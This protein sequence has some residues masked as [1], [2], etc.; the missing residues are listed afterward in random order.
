MRIVPDSTITLYTGVDID[1]DEQLVFKN[2]TN[3][4]AYFHS[5]IHPQ[6]VYTPCTVVRKTGRLRVEKTGSIVSACNYLSF[7]NPSFDNK[8][9]YARIIDYD[10][11]NNECTEISYV[12]DYWQT[13]M[14]DVT[15]QDM[16]IEREH[17]SQADWDKAEAN[18]YDQSILEFKTSESL[19]VGRDVE[20][21]FY[22][23]GAGSALEDGA[24]VG[25]RATQQYG[26]ND[27]IGV[28][29]VFSN[30]NLKDLDTSNPNNPPSIDLS[31][32]LKNVAYTWSIL[33][34][35]YVR[36]SD[37]SAFSLT[38]ET[39]TYLST[40]DTG[41]SN[42]LDTSYSQPY[43]STG[44][45]WDID[46]HKAPFTSS[47][48][49]T[50]VNYVYYDP[51][52]AGSA[53][54]LLDWFTQVDKLDC[55]LGVYGLPAGLMLLSGA[56]VNSVGF[57]VEMATASGQNVVNKKLDLFP[58]SYYRLIA[59]N[60][61][62]KELRIED[63]RTVQISDSNS[64]VGLS[65]D[66]VEKPN[67]LIAPVD[68]KA[69]GMSPH[70]IMSG[71]NSVEGMVFSQFPCLPYDIDGFKSQMAAIANSIIGNNTLEYSYDMQQQSLEGYG[72]IA[73]QI[74]SAVEF[75]GSIPA[76]TSNPIAFIESL[77]KMVKTGWDFMSGGA[78][79]DI[80]Q[81]RRE[82]EWGMNQDAYQVL[83]GNTNNAVYRNYEYTKPA[84]AAN[85]YHP[86]NGDGVLN[87]NI[88]CFCDILFM[89][90]SLHPQILAQYDQYFSNYGYSSGRCGIPRVINY[91][92]GSNTATDVPH[93][94]TLN[95]KQTTY[96]KTMDCKVIHSMLPVAQFIKAMF[97]KGVRMI[98]GDATDG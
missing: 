65:M 36:R 25:V 45:Q 6:G 63:F 53:S 60:G 41:F 97:D 81:G 85:I 68:Y 5:K 26:L 24:F 90:V 64:I 44:D 40:V 1:N 46:G 69:I 83:S 79:H 3:Q 92:H 12:I 71:M 2:A 9:I 88:N 38:R 91:V 66:I 87:Y 27:G 13:W 73:Q 23:I 96:I 8:T 30:I 10:Y 22:E 50:P 32:I 59:P 4:A 78:Q 72:E 51:S 16:Y 39:C 20:K 86:I 55:I 48:M 14:F 75:I 61:D 93:W 49:K 21:P 33:N 29:I 52:Q 70:N 7:V 43:Q 28:L 34:P 89:R 76:Q 37:L 19:T 18:P 95:G 80:N 94:Q 47:R 84:Y 56:D 58:F 42:V 57:R 98:Q 31:T 11:I 77:G 54:S 74:A 67:L 62:I 35:T 17:L 15:F 82:N